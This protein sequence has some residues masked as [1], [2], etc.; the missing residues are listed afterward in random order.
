MKAILSLLLLAGLTCTARA[1]F[2][3]LLETLEGRWVE[4]DRRSFMEWRFIDD[5]TISGRLYSLLGTD[6]LERAR[7]TV[8]CHGLTPVLIL[9]TAAGELRFT[10]SRFLAYEQDWVSEQG[11]ASPRHLHLQRYP[12]SRAVVR[13]DNEEHLYRPLN[14]AVVRFSAALQAGWIQ[15]EL[16]PVR[17]SPQVPVQYQRQ[18][19]SA[20]RGREFAVAAGFRGRRSAIGCQLE[21]SRIEKSYRVDEVLL[22]QS[23]AQTYTLAGTYH[24]VSS[25]L[26]VVPQFFF[27]RRQA[28]TASLSWAFPLR[29]Q[30]EFDGKYWVNP[31]GPADQPTKIPRGRN[32][33]MPFGIGMA[34][35][36]LL[37][38]L[39]G[40][41]PG[42]YLRAGFFPQPGTVRTLSAGL[43]LAI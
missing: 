40:L 21:Y 5:Q 16:L 43:R 24:Q 26:S 22:N 27:G 3:P 34:Y 11:D 14:Q 39:G 1:Q 25:Y 2:I 33:M 29:Q 18:D 28:W 37:P 35:T 36:P 9:S 30:E 8:L 32:T 15:G 41:R 10:P 31:G 20:V 12:G 4:G 38:W 42:L 13:I 19:Y 6:T 23:S 17:I 7:M